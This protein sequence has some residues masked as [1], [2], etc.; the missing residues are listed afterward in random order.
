MHARS[1][2]ALSLFKRLFPKSNMIKI[3]AHFQLDHTQ[4]KFPHNMPTSLRI[5]LCL[6]FYGRILIRIPP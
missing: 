6:W 2:V 1:Y 5:F 3:S 4:L